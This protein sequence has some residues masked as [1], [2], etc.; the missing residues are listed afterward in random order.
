MMADNEFHIDDL[1]NVNISIFGFD[2]DHHVVPIRPIQNWQVYI[3]G[4]E[5]K[6]CFRYQ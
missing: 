5:A 4:R 6:K 1:R 2:I 3:H